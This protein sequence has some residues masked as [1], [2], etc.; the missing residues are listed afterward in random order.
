VGAT[1]DNA[2]GWSVAMASDRSIRVSWDDGSGF[3]PGVVRRCCGALGDVFE[4]G[5]RAEVVAAARSIVV[6][7]SAGWLAERCDDAGVVEQLLER[8]RGVVGE[9]L[10]AEAGDGEAE[11]GRTITI[12]VRYGGADGPDLESVAAHCGLSEEEVIARHAGAEYR[13]GFMGFSPGFGYLVGLPGELA[14]PRL[15]SP[16]KRVAAGSV[17]IAGSQTG[18]YPQATPGGWR[19]IGRT[20]EVMFDAE[21]E[22]PSLLRVGDVVRFVVDEA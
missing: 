3:D 4:R 1:R 7:V 10:S 22:R 16:R 12:R 5:A 15:S 11:E 6:R 14:T 19:L 20:S 17:G 2:A 18:V 21:R 8:C 13:V 9:A